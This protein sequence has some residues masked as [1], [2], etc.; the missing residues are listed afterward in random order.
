MALRI[1]RLAF[2][3]PAAVLEEAACHPA[4]TGLRARLRLPDRAFLNLFFFFFFNQRMFPFLVYNGDYKQSASPLIIVS[5]SD[6]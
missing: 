2:G 5:G 1:P 4:P 6:V 3:S